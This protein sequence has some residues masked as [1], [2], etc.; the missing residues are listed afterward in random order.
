MFSAQKE[1]SEFFLRVA[2]YFVTIIS[3]PVLSTVQKLFWKQEKEIWI[4]R[5]QR[6]YVILALS[7]S[8]LKRALF[9]LICGN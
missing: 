8:V 2:I 7:V 5:H 3:R 1:V 9:A 4:S 6:N